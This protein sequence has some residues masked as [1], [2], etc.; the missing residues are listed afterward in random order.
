MADETNDR[1]DHDE[2]H[3]AADVVASGPRSEYI[4]LGRA[5]VGDY[6]VKNKKE[7]PPW[8]DLRYFVEQREAARKLGLKVPSRPKKVPGEDEDE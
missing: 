8:M 6:V 7:R 1:H 5:N 2:L 3:A 4:D